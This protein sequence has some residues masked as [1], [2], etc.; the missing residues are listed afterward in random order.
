[1]QPLQ[2][3]LPEQAE[4]KGVSVTGCTTPGQVRGQETFVNTA[5]GEIDV[6]LIVTSF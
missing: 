6:L 5:S 4:R 2:R 3:A 1:M